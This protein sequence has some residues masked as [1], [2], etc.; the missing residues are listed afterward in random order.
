MGSYDAKGQ[1]PVIHPLPSDHEVYPLTPMP[2]LSLTLTVSIPFDESLNSR[3]PTSTWSRSASNISCK[4]ILS[5]FMVKEARKSDE[6]T[7]MD[8]RYYGCLLMLDVF[9]FSAI[10]APTAEISTLIEDKTMQQ[11]CASYISMLG[12]LHSSNSLSGRLF[13]FI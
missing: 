2:R 1:F 9:Q 7:L 6:M 11:E 12:Q 10:Y 4:V 5:S 13:P 8:F 3:M